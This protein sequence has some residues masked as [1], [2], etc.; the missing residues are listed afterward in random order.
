[1]DWRSGFVLNRLVAKAEA[2]FF[3]HRW[4]TLAAVGVFTALMAVFAFRLH[5]SA[6][7]EKQMPV[8]HEYTQTFEKYRGDLFG[9]NRL[10]F[11]VKARTGTI[12][13]QDALMRLYDVTQAV[14]YLPNVTGWGSSRCGPPIPTS[15]RSRKRDSAPTRSST[16]RSPRRH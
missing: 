12:W 1:M 3:G 15:T 8:G 10:N 7:F 13:N 6:G 4:Q 9:A 5:M 16:G 2:F 11:V 14:Q